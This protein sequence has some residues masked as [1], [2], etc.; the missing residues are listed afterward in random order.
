MKSERK[1]SKCCSLLEKKKMFLKF[2]YFFFYGS[3]GSI[4]NLTIRHRGLTDLEISIINLLIPFL[5]FLTNTIIGSIADHIRR[6]RLIFSSTL[7]FLIL[8]SF[9]SLKY[10]QLQGEIY[11]NQ[12]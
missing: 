6:Y 5:C 7:T 3:I 4:L 11:Q 9:S 1:V 2:H 12:M 10:F 8:F